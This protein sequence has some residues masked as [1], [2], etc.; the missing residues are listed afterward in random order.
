MKNL[1]I[2][3]FAI[4]AGLSI[5]SMGGYLSS[6]VRAGAKAMFVAD[7]LVSGMEKLNAFEIRAANCSG[8]SSNPSVTDKELMVVRDLRQNKDDISPALID[9]ADARLATRIAMAAQTGSDAHLP[10]DR[11]KEVRGLLEKAGWRNP[12]AAHMREIINSLDQEQCRA[13]SGR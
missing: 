10:D 3:A 11:E 13:A 5:G 12:S 4:V 2:Y 8:G 9:V 1:P 7:P 6:L